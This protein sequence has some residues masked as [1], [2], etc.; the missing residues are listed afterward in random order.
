ME[1]ILHLE[2]MFYKKTETFIINQI[3]TISSYL[4][5]VVCIQNNHQNSFPE[6]VISPPGNNM[7]KPFRTKILNTRDNNYLKNTLSHKS[8]ALLHT[9]FISDA[10]FFNPLT[11]NMRIPK[12]VS[13]YGYD[14]SEFPERFFGYGKMY[15]KK[16]FD[17]YNL[18]LAMSEDMK[19]DLMKIGCPENKILIH[20]HGI[21]TGYFTNNQRTYFNKDHYNLISV[22]T[23]CEKKGQHLIIEALNIIINFYNKKNIRYEI[24]GSGPNEKYIQNKISEY[25]LSAYVKMSGHINYGPLLKSKYATADVFLHPSIIDSN[26]GKE[27]IPGVI[28]EAMSNGLPVVTTKHAGIPSIIKDNFNGILVEESNVEELTDAILQILDSSNLRAKL[29]NNAKM[30]ACENL[31]MYKKAKYLEEHIYT[32]L[33][34]NYTS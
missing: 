7:F 3:K 11:S 34:S 29:G 30:Y 15:L 32:N 6:N 1:T 19:A 26:G 8:Y 2:R 4:I 18:V 13:A 12:V 31:N 20:Y 24:V 10:A 25:N 21:D 33:I 27:G 22:G 17:E 23:L 28:V 9:H 16:V 14:V 5:D